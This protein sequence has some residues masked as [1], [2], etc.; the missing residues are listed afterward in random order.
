MILRLDSAIEITALDLTFGSG[1]A[2][3]FDERRKKNWRW[4]HGTQSLCVAHSA[5]RIHVEGRPAIHLSTATHEARPLLT[6]PCSNKGGNITMT[7]KNLLK[8]VSISMVVAMVFLASVGDIARAQVAGA[9][10]L[11]TVTDPAGAVIANAQVTIQDADTGGTRTVTTNSAG[12]YAAPNLMPGK[13]ELRIS[14]PGFSAGVA[15]VILTVG[16]EQTVNVALKVGQATTSVDVTDAVSGVELATSSLGNEVDANTVREL[17]LNGRDW[18]QLATLQPGI[19]Q[20]RNQSSIGGV[21]SADVVRGAR[22]FGNQLSVSGT[23][24][25]QN[26][27]RLDGI[28]FNDYTNGAPGG[29]LGALAGVDAIQEFSVLT[30][31][32]SAEYGKTSGGVINA[33]TRSGT[34]KFHGEAYEFLRNSSLDARNY[35]D[36]PKVPPFRRNQ[37]GAAVG[38]PMVKDKTFFF[39]NYEGLRQSLSSTQVDITPSQNARQGILSTGN[40][41]VDPAIVPFLQFWLHVVADHRHARQRVG[42]VAD[43]R[44]ALDRIGDLAVLD[45]VGLGGGEHELAAG[46]V[47]LAAAEVDRVQAVLDRGDDLLRVLSPFSI[48]VLVMRGI[49]H[50]RKRFAPPVAGD[51]HA[52]QARVHACPAGS[53]AACR[54]RSARCAA[55]GCLRR[56][57]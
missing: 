35:F 33:I 57:R 30:T 48:K 27:Y 32:Y 44:R 10:I 15:S 50:V 12:F 25:T 2:V 49:G 40:V 34:N 1:G 28:S 19:D 38:G 47:H 36:G 26:N 55:W 17:P 43:Q 39:F 16:A 22:G 18:S 52:H 56:R 37:F 7:K 29:V 9:T 4:G 42:A 41:N 23:R 54:L 21:G 24:P 13:Y 31:N 11:G 53:R 51:R 8:R 46:D 3:L 14:A 20:V 45:H 6:T 5:G